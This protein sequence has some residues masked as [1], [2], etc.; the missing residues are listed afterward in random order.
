MWS[1]KI[2]DTIVVE[3]SRSKCYAEYSTII[4]RYNPFT[5]CH[6][7]EPYS[8]HIT[9]FTDNFPNMQGYPF[10]YAFMY[11]PPYSD[12]K[13]TLTGVEIKGVDKILSETLADKMNYTGMIK[14]VPKNVPFLNK[15][16]NGTVYGII[17]EVA[18]GKYDA[19][20]T[21]TAM[22]KNIYPISPLQQYSYPLL[23]DNWCVVAPKLV[24]KNM[25]SN[26]VINLFV[27]NFSIVGIFWLCSRLM[28]FNPSRWHPLNIISMILATSLPPAPTT[29]R[30]RLIYLSV[31]TVYACYSSV[32][33]IELTST[34]VKGNR[35]VEFNNLQDVIDADLTLMV[36]L[37]T[38]KVIRRDDID[39]EQQFRISS[40]KILNVTQL[41]I[42]L[43]DLLIYQNVSCLL[44]DSLAKLVAV[45]NMQNGETTI[46]MTELC[47]ISSS[48]SYMFPK[49]SPYVKRI[50]NIILMLVEGGFRDKWYRDFL[51]NETRESTFQSNRHQM[52]SMYVNIFNS[53]IYILITGYSISVFVFIGELIS[54][55]VDINLNLCQLIYS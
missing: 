18:A 55:Y 46:M 4:H 6:T 49:E 12:F 50:S 39:F 38:L 22:I 45:S 9:W 15:R 47:Y 42:C 19:L 14:I 40:K 54:K 1:R 30:E 51:R 34:N 8:T 48:L 35:Y 2:L 7:V 37:E 29:F 20:L 25:N 27:I 31:L 10:G 24:K 16:P 52:D 33:F 26:S 44:T 53:L 43:Q 11:R 17:P 36:H 41:D 23:I 3:Y 13:L 5:D 32:L 21:T 28:K